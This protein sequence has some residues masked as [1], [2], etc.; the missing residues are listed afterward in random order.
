MAVTP[1]SARQLDVLRQLSQLWTP[2]RFV[3]IGAAALGCFLE[4]RWRGTADLDL[5]LAI[6]LDEF[7]DERLVPGW[8]RDRWMEH[9]WYAPGGEIVD[10]I[11][12]GPELLRAG[13][14]QWPRTGHRMSLVGIR[15]AFERGVPVSVAPDLIVKVAPVPVLT[16]LKIVAYEERPA[17]RERDLADL[18]YIFTEYEPEERFADDVITLGMSYEEIG[19]FLLARTI[20]SMVNDAERAHVNRFVRKASDEDDPSG[21]HAKLLASGP[22]SWRREPDELMRCMRAFTRGFR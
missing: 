13:E 22:P 10:I 6:S 8:G 14:V 21:T 9:R 7:L 4:M 15:L 3:L 18:A 2:E 11:P 19:P 5:T 1:F 17:E 12:A 20:A 16:V